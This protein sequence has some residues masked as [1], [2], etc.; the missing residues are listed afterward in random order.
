MGLIVYINGALMTAARVALKVNIASVEFVKK[1]PIEQIGAIGACLA[2]GF[3]EGLEPVHLSWAEMDEEQEEIWRWAERE[4]ER[5]PGGPFEYHELAY[6]S[7]SMQQMREERCQIG[8]HEPI[9]DGGEWATPTGRIVPDGIELRA[10]LSLSSQRASANSTEPHAETPVLTETQIDALPDY[11]DSFDNSPSQ[12]RIPAKLCAV[13]H[14]K[15]TPSDSSSDKESSASWWSP[16]PGTGPIMST[17]QFDA[18]PDW[19][20]VEDDSDWEDPT[21]SLPDLNLVIE[22]EIR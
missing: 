14:P 20:D 13:K 7:R 5:F 3:E 9:S 22:G 8:D 11:D 4:W 18:L 6:F 16:G 21:N 15:V 2:G 12:N 10:Y 17:V 19:S 1:L